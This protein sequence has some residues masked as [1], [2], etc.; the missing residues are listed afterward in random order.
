MSASAGEVA[1]AIIGLSEHDARSRVESDGFV[2]RVIKRDGV[3]IPHR[4]D[5]RPNRISVEI[6][7]GTVTGASVY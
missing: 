5:K 2:W 6:T 1:V 7:D 3:A 4:L